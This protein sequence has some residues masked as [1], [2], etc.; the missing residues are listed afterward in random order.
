MV[1]GLI[2]RLKCGAFCIEVYNVMRVK[3]VLVDRRMP[4]R[5]IVV[6]VFQHSVLV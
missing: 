3:H 5:L 6:Y 1:W 4:K 2:Q